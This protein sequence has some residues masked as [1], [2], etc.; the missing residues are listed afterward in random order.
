MAGERTLPGL[1]LRSY[2]TPGSNGYN[3]TL[4]PD[5]RLLSI[6]CQCKVKSRTTALPGVPTAGDIYIVKVGDTDEKKI[7]AWDDGAWVIITP[8]AGYI[9]WVENAAEL[10]K[11]DGTNWTTVLRPDVLAVNTYTASRTLTIDNKNGLCR[12]D[13]ATALTLTVPQNSDVAFPVGT[14][15]HLRQ[16]GAG[17][18][19]IA[20]GLSVTIYTPETLALRK[21]G[22]SAALVK[23]D[24]N[25]WDLTGDLEALP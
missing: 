15:V 7:A 1:G 12:M 17:Q 11:F 3:T 5:I 23:V 22:S 24:T 18:L 10:V 19:V 8:S 9:A 4:D 25:K 6:L 14:V 16:V 21:A 20:P 13:K 2:W